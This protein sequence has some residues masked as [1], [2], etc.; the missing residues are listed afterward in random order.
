M[1]L[2]LAGLLAAPSF[3]REPVSLSVY[4]AS[5]HTP[6]RT[7]ELSLT[8][9]GSAQPLLCAG[10]TVVPLVP[11]GKVSANTPLLLGYEEDCSFLLSRLAQGYAI[12][13]QAPTDGQVREALLT[14][15]TATSPLARGSAYGYLQT[16][17]F[18]SPTYDYA[19]LHR[20][21]SAVLPRVAQT[22]SLPYE[23]WFYG[24]CDGYES[25]FDTLSA[26]DLTP[27]GFTA[28]LSAPPEAPASG[29]L[30]TEPRLWLAALC[31]SSEADLLTEGETYRFS[32]ET[33][34]VSATLLPVRREGERALL[35]FDALTFPSVLPPRTSRVS[36]T[37]SAPSA[38]RVPACAVRQQE[39]GTFVYALVGQR[40]LA[41]GVRVREEDGVWAYVE[42]DPS[43]VCGGETLR[44]LREHEAVIWDGQNLYHR[45]ILP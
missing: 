29:K 12:P 45:K 37:L 39:S 6:T 20:E 19:A 18:P 38:L 17:L 11:N 41:R 32:L 33:G 34:T 36:L 13:S 23:G 44:P 40:V 8:A 42:P 25:V 9:F 10:E 7:L 15:R 31:S 4:P 16:L 35:L 26:E 21:W 24:E 14:L 30:Y 2:L 5:V 1:L 3:K 27:S 43:V 22:V 28:L